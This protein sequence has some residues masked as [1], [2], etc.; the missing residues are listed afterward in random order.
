MK[1]CYG[2]G[3]GLRQYLSYAK[4]GAVVAIGQVVT[5]LGTLY[6]VR[7]LTLEL[8][9]E[10]YGYLVL[11]LTFL[12]LVN[13][14]V[15]GGV[16]SGI[17][18][19][20]SVA[21]EERG[22]GSFLKS[23]LTLLLGCHLSIVVLCSVSSVWLHYN[24][25]DAWLL[26]LVVVAVGGCVDVFNL[27]CSHIQSA[28][29]KRMAVSLTSAMNVWLRVVF[30]I[31]LFEYTDLG[32]VIK[33]EAVVAVYLFASCLVAIVHVLL[34]K[35]TIGLKYRGF[36]CDSGCSRD[37]INQYGA[38]LGLFRFLVFLYGGSR[39]QIDGRWKCMVLLL[40]LECMPLHFSLV[41]VQQI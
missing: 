28:A 29:R 41:L 14:L 4:E 13:Q 12:V 7:L 37:W 5:A 24:Q 25:L 3:G 20:Y 40:M 38:T 36:S 33:V 27:I 39:F 26:V 23:C 17:G 32:D 18:R 19:Y 21:L 30:L 9:P 2:L 16:V 11:V 10:V 15:S 8:S 6:L 22:I 1:A 35:R 31:V 34:L